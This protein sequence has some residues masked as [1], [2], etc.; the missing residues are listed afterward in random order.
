MFTL[1]NRRLARAE[2]K[3]FRAGSQAALGRMVAVVSHEIKNPLMILRAA[4]ERLMKKYGDPEASIVVEEVTRLDRIVCGYLAFARGDSTLP[5]EPVDLRQVAGQVQV[6]YQKYWHDQNVEV[7]W[8]IADDLPIIIGDPIGL[9]QVLVNLLLNAVEAVA[10]HPGSYKRVAI[11]VTGANKSALQILVSDNG[12][13]LPRDLHDRL[14][15]PFQTTKTAGSGLGLYLCRRIVESHMGTI[16]LTDMRPGW[17][18]FEV[19]LPAGGL[20]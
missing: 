3:L 12:P 8:T 4:G 5:T 13:G 17:T 10:A 15:E 14:F 16:S 7:A 19:R 1:Y 11:S 20:R 6:A 2:E 18:T 9:R